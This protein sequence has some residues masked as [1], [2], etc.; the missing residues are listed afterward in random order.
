MVNTEY[1]SSGISLGSYNCV[2]R[3]VFDFRLYPESRLQSPLNVWGRQDAGLFRGRVRGRDRWPLTKAE[4]E[5][6]RHPAGLFRGRGSV[7]PV[8]TE[9]SRK[10]RRAVPQQPQAA[11]RIPM[12]EARG[13]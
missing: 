2:Y 5:W 3:L 4:T 7:L 13:R 11:T 1:G 9:V 6:G 8:A 12:P 10:A